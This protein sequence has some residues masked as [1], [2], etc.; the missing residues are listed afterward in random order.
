MNIYTNVWYISLVRITKRGQKMLDIRELQ[1]RFSVLIESR[2]NSRSIGGSSNL[3]SSSPLRAL[4]EN[5]LNRFA[6]QLSDQAVI[7][8]QKDNIVDDLLENVVSSLAIAGMMGINLEA[9]IS[10]LLNLLESVSAEAS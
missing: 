1:E 3:I 7:A 5:L 10:N 2:T 8:A 6:Y 9:E 4:G